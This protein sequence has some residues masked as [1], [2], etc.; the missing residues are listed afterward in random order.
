MQN[1]KERLLKQEIEDF[2]QK[3]KT[4]NVCKI[5]ED[6]NK[7]LEEIRDKKLKKT[8]RTNDIRSRVQWLKGERPSIFL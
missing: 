5:L 3:E 4:P 1:E 6:K 7:E 8:K 2:D